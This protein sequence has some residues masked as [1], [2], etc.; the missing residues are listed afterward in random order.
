[1][2]DLDGD[3]LVALTYGPRADW[4]R[5]V[6]VGDATLEN[7]AGVRHIEAIERVGRDVA[8]PA[9]PWFVRGALRVLTVHDFARLR[10]AAPS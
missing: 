8:W 7:D 2:F 5:N 4:F 3:A 9:L 6:S 1:M 10:I